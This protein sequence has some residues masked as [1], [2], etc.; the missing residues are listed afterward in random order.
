M[1]KGEAFSREKTSQK[2]RF[3]VHTGQLDVIVT[4]TQF[5]VSTREDK[6]SVLLTRAA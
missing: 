1:V 3:I 2:N 6:T 5:N 4:G